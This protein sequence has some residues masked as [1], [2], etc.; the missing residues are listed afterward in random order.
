MLRIP[1]KIIM[2]VEPIWQ[3][4][5]TKTAAA[6]RHKLISSE[7]VVRA[8]VARMRAVNP[9]IN[10]VVYDLGDKAI[11]QAILAD[12]DLEKNGP[13]GPL[14]GVPVTIKQNINVAGLPNPNGVLAF[15]DLIAKQNASPVD[16]LLK[17]GAI[18]IG[19]TNTPEFSLRGFTDNP[20]HG[21][22]LNPWNEKI[23]CGGSSGGA[24]SSLAMGIG[25]I[26]H[27]SD[28]GG[29]LRWPAH[30]NGL[31]TIKSTFGRIPFYS[32]VSGNERPLTFQM[33]S[34]QGPMGR[35]VEDVILGLQV[36]SQRDYRDPWWVPAPLEFKGDPIKRV[37]KA[38]IPD[39][40]ETDP[41]VVAEFHKAAEWLSQAG[42][43]IEEIDLPN[44][45]RVWELWVDLIVGEARILL[46]QDMMKVAGM[47]F[48][49]AFHS[50]EKL[51]ERPKM[52]G[53]LLEEAERTFHLRNW[54]EILEKYSVILTPA[55]TLP[56]FEAKED[57]YGDAALHRIYY[58]GLRFISSINILGLPAAVVPVGLVDGNP[59]GVQIIS[60]RFREDLC[61]AAAKEIENK[62]GILV[63]ELWKREE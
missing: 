59:V 18:I 10:A 52:K 43:E 57:T 1:G 44:L 22:T 33:S 11:E 50:M 6:I 31:A 23:T 14:H 32:G 45:N 20:L 62:A 15:K 19:L 25:A 2:M 51:S 42:Y 48:K 3:W 13:K 30:C 47:D 17:A 58:H 37:A 5:A 12:R 28:L 38:K 41:K 9:K 56:T 63:R 60:S 36:L 21:L 53:I 34:I 54:L 39:D 49:K 55:S 16:N 61:L 8:H 27:G 46:Q 40:M 26:A 4:S 7:E 29:S 35:C 24:A